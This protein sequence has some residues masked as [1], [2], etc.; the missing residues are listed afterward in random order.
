M[1]V[2]F[3][4]GNYANSRS[5]P[6]R[7]NPDLMDFIEKHVAALIRFRQKGDWRL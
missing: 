7:V 6:S 3:H 2:T 1:P 4:I 5:A